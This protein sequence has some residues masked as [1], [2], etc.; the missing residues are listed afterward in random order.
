MTKSESS[1][2]SVQSPGNMNGGSKQAEFDNTSFIAMRTE[3]EQA[4]PIEDPNNPEKYLSIIEKIK[5]E[6]HYVEINSPKNVGVLKQVIG[7]GGCYFKM[8]TEN[9]GIAYIWHNTDSQKIE[10]WGLEQKSLEKAKSII[11][12]RIER[13]TRFKKKGV[14]PQTS[15]N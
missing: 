5:A 9:T 14:D 1:P 8:T 7:R 15:Y 11:N 13:Y 10:F 3:F 2:N 6:N 4:H 12:D